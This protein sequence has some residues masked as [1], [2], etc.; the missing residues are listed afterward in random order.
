MY[1]ILIYIC[2]VFSL[3]KR[4]D[5]LLTNRTE[6]FNLQFLLWPDDVSYKPK[7]AAKYRYFKN[8]VL[9]LTVEITR[10]HVLL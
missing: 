7:L 6:F 1:K 2:H 3:V 8:D 5:I 9:D 4:G 10:I